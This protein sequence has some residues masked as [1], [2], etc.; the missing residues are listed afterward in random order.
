[1]RMK[2]VFVSVYV[3]LGVVDVDV[4]VCLLGTRKMVKHVRLVVRLVKSVF[5]LDQVLLSIGETF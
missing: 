5:L 3:S 1:M 4:D 2:R